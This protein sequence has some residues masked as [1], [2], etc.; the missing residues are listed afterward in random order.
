[1]KMDPKFIITLL[2]LLAVCVDCF[3][4]PGPPPPQTPPGP[5]GFPIDSGIVYL[6]VVALL[7]GGFKLYNHSQKLRENA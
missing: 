4:D 3:A 1:M 6:V 7:Y 2:T 5:P